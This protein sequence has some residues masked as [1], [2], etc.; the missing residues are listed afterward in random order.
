MVPTLD[1]VSPSRQP[2]DSRL[3]EEEEGGVHEAGRFK[4]GLNES[5]ATGGRKQN[6]LA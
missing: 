5:A 6:K 2:P 4:E 3:E 1:T